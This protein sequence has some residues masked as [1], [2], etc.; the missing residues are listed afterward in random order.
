MTGDPEIGFCGVLLSGDVS[1]DHQRKAQIE[2][3][4][5][6]QQVSASNQRKRQGNRVSGQH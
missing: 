4:I 2:V 5:L 6:R 3:G 1:T